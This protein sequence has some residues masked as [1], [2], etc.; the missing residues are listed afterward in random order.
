MTLNLHN[1]LLESVDYLIAAL[2]RELALEVLVGTITVFLCSLFDL[3]FLLLG[4]L[5]LLV[6]KM[7]VYL[8]FGGIN[9]CSSACI[10][11]DRVRITV[12]H[13]GWVAGAMRICCLGCL[14][15]NIFSLALDNRNRVIDLCTD[16]ASGEIWLVVPCVVWS[17][18]VNLV[19][20][21]LARIDLIS[22]LGCRIAR[23]VAKQN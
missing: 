20:L 19:E 7:L 1:H 16:T 17:R 23:N 15:S 8:G 14:T 11:I 13:S 10:G 22:S 9:T 21:V 5:L 3:F 2:F 18:M 4:F 6:R 12:G